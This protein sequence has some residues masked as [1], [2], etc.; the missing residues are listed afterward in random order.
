MYQL[1]TEQTF[2]AAHFLYDYEGKCRNLHGHEW[3]VII[4]VKNA[5]LEGIGQTRD[6]VVDFGT[7]KA[8][9]KEE[10]DAFDHCLIV[11]TGSLKPSTLTA[12]KEEHFKI[13]EMDYR[14]TA[15]RLA[16][17][18]YDRMTARGY[19]VVRSTVYETPKNCATYLP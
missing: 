2:D 8:D 11:E 1:K 14:P 3:L 6:M 17:Y 7:L 10:T 16:K 12:L 19:Q 15:E 5:Q 18:F 9:L 13:I 4:E